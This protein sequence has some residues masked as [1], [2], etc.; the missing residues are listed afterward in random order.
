MHSRMLS[1][2]FLMYLGLM[3]TACDSV[4]KS[5]E[6]TTSTASNNVQVLENVLT[7]PQLNRSRTIRLYLPPDYEQ[8]NVHYPVVYMHDGQN[9]FDNSTAPYGEWQIDES[10][11]EL[12]RD[13]Q[14]NIIVVGIDNG[15]DDYRLHELSPWENK[16]YGKAEGEEY[17]EFIVKT[18]KPYIDQRYRTLPERENTAIFGSS[19]GGLISHYLAFNYPEV[20]GKVGILSPSYWYSEQVFDFTYSH[21][22]EQSLAIYMATGAKEPEIMRDNHRKM[23]RVFSETGSDNINVRAH[24]VAEADHNES[25][26]SNEFKLG[27]LWLFQ[28]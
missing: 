8:S 26:W 3:L 27:I 22:P 15:G 24:I 7:I 5:Q 11:N 6:Q 19:M 4:S 18:L 23:L 2:T 1:S 12:A 16:E 20:F 28:T 13:S 17:A 10:L 21:Q 25:F 14:F 9:L